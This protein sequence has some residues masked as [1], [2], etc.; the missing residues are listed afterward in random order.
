MRGLFD[1]DHLRPRTADDIRH[2]AARNQPHHELDAFRTRLPDIFDVRHL[3][4]A[5]GV[6]N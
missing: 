1:A 2:R 4:E 6:V 5:L 3:R